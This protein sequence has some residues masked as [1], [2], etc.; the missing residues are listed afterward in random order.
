[1]CAVQGEGQ[2]LRN[3]HE[4]D[5]STG[6][7]D[8]AGAG[9]GGAVSNSAAVAAAAASRREGAE[10]DERRLVEL[11]YKTVQY[12]VISHIATE[13]LAVSEGLFVCLDGW[14]RCT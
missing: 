10:R 4:V 3:G 5:S 12:Y 13:K 8:A 1:M 2:A 14:C 7:G 9:A 6:S 11:G